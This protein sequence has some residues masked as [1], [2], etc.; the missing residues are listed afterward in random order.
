M[1]QLEYQA[2]PSLRDVAHDGWMSTFIRQWH[3]LCRYTIGLWCLHSTVHL[4]CHSSTDSLPP[5]HTPPLTT[6]TAD[7][8]QLHYDSFGSFPHSHCP[9][10]Y[11]IYVQKV[12]IQPSVATLRKMTIQRLQ[13]DTCTFLSQFLIHTLCP[14]CFAFAVSAAKIR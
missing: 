2:M 5:Q 8:L 4:L 6:S 13:E 10:P 7:C 12:S 3:V 11:S 9:L 14:T 1:G